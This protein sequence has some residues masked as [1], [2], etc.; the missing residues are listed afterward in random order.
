MD[1]EVTKTAKEK[2]YTKLFQIVVPFMIAGIGMVGAGL[3]F[4][5]FEACK[6][7]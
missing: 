2:W 4:N 7:K 1:L 6:I 3:L 5:I